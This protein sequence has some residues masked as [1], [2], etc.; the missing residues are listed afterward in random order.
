[1]KRT[2]LNKFF[3]P[4]L[5]TASFSDDII[6]SKQCHQFPFRNMLSRITKV[7]DV[8]SKRGIS[9]TRTLIAMIVTKKIMTCLVEDMM[10]DAENGT[11]VDRKVIQ[12]CEDVF[13]MPRVCFIQ[14][15]DD[16][17]WE[18]YYIRNHQ[19]QN[20]FTEMIIQ[21]KKSWWVIRIHYYQ[22]K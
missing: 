17:I 8:K 4:Y 14:Y 11:H 12:I 10:S 20:I 15:Q 13:R 7:Q 3:P 2:S 16:R 5:F 18:F 9:R 6:V 1:M 19:L 21:F 22:N